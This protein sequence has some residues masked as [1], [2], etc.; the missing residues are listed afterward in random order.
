MLVAAA[1]DTFAKGC[2]LNQGTF[3]FVMVQ[4]VLVQEEGPP[5]FSR[6]NEG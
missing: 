6:Y 2:T 5:P 1:M 3:S 4:Q